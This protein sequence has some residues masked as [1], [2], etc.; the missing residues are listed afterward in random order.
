MAEVGLRT[1]LSGLPN[2]SSESLRDLGLLGDLPLQQRSLAGQHEGASWN[3]RKDLIQLR[4]K[5]SYEN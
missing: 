1:T 5:T 2:T 4:V 3:A